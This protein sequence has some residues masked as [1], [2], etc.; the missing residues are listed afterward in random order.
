MHVA[1]EEDDALPLRSV[2]ARARFEWTWLAVPAILIFGVGVYLLVQ[3]E[4]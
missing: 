2:G 4:R 3:S 1:L